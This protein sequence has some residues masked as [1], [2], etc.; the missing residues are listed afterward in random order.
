MGAVVAAEG[1]HGKLVLSL[2][3]C[4]VGQGYPTGPVDGRFGFRTAAALQAFQLETGLPATGEADPETWKAVTT[5]E[6]PSLEERVLQ[7]TSAFETRD[8]THAQGNFDGAGITW[9]ILG[10]T[11]RNRQVQRIV[12][13]ALAKDPSLVESAF[14]EETEELLTVLDGRLGDQIAWAD[15]RSSGRDK[16][17]LDEPWRAHFR[18]FGVQPAVQALQLDRVH[19]DYFLPALRTARS[20][21]LSSELGVAL[22][23]DIH[24]QDGGVRPAAA[25]VVAAKRNGGLPEPGVRVLLADA[26]ASLAR[27]EYRM[28]I[29]DRKLAIARGEGTVRGA[30]YVLRSWGLDEAG[31]THPHQV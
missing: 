26:V 12:R 30:S 3:Q 25:E 9:G 17:L 31:A 14:G 28:E 11:L 22:C 10:F 6:P 4:L 16:A 8:F 29:H 2:Q 23:F 21:S 18:A 7:L 13:E 24:V 1:A 27:S 20:F 5:L 19:E 15:R